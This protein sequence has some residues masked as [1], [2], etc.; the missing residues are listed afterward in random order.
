MSNNSREY[1]ISNENLLLI[2]ILNSMYNDNIRQINNLSESIHLLNDTNS[3][4][5]NLLTQILYTNTN[6][7]TNR[8]NQFYR[9]NSNRLNSFRQ[10]PITAPSHIR[11][12]VRRVTANT[13]V[14]DFLTNESHSE[15]DNE[16]GN[17]YTTRNETTNV[18]R[19]TNVSQFWQ[20]FFQP[21]AIFPTQTQIETATRTVQYG[22]IVS[23]INRA[24]PI[25]LENFNDTDIVSVIRF[26]RHIFRRDELNTR[27]RTNCRCPVCRYDIR[28]YQTNIY[29]ETQDN[30]NESR[31]SNNS[32]NVETQNAQSN[33]EE[34]NQMLSS[35]RDGN[36]SNSSIVFDIYFDNNIF[37]DISG[38]FATNNTT[39]ISLLSSLLNN[40]L[41]NSRPFR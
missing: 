4:I 27:F 32:E 3:E 38:N 33:I 5:R 40:A 17:V 18:N 41:N 29:T 31:E 1:N 12:N 16:S 34:T 10:Q 23:P 14:Y 22:D 20:N 26:C 28:N 39:D 9:P 11:S 36:T 13:G 6:T 7:N 25:S 35:I 30:Q 24:C 37:R 19:N 8:R 21:I 2:S 15:N